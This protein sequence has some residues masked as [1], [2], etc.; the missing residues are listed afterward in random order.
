MITSFLLWEF[1][2]FEDVEGTPQKT[3]MELSLEDP[4]IDRK[5][6]LNMLTY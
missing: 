5:I 1:D 4:R 2:S 6:N 3:Q